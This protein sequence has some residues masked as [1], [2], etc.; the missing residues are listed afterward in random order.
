MPKK[1]VLDEVAEQ[2]TKGLV[3]DGKVI[4]AGWISYWKMVVPPDAGRVQIEECKLAFMAGAQH[5]FDTINS[6]LEEGED[7]TEADV[8]RMR[9]IASELIE[10]RERVTARVALSRPTEGSA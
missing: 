9:M 6:V 8:H 10:W 1:R 4:E 5:L 3:D 2:I 7:A